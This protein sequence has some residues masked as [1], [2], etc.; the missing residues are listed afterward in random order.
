VDADVDP[1]RLPRVI[2]GI[3]LLALLVGLVLILGDV[4]DARGWLAGLGR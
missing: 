2:W 1:D 4:L 3:A